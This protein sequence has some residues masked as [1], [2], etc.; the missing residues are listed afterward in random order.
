MHKYPLVCLQSGY[1][2][3]RPGTLIQARSIG[4]ETGQG[5]ADFMTSENKDNQ[6]CRYTRFEIGLV[7]SLL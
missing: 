5:Y 7:Q 4:K 2:R 3:Q 6:R 1:A